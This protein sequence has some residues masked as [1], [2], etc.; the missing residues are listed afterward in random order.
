MW[1]RLVVKII[2]VKVFGH[3]IQFV[4]EYWNIVIFYLIHFLF[5]DVSESPSL[6]PL[7]V[8][9]D[10]A[11]LLSCPSSTFI[12]PL[13]EYWNPRDSNT[14]DF[15]AVGLGDG[16]GS[17]GFGDVMSIAEADPSDAG[18]YACAEVTEGRVYFRQL[19]SLV[20]LKC[21]YMV[22]YLKQCLPFVSCFFVSFT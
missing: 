7:Y 16:E 2:E 10:S 8:E 14:T 11:V 6:Q 5:T 3:L 19:Y 9:H 21:K 1:R 22:G 18:L 20:V 17:S 4:A 15:H 12:L 13:P